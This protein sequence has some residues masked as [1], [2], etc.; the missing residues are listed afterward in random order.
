[1]TFA[2]DGDYDTLRTWRRPMIAGRPDAVRALTA[3][4]GPQ[5]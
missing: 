4:L 5:A 2:E 3:A 1:V